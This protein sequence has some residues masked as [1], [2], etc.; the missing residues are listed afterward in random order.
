M[1]S[2]RRDAVKREIQILT[3]LD[4]PNIIKCFEVI[5]EPKQVLKL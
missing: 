4:H 2:Q 5:D 1:D 3:K